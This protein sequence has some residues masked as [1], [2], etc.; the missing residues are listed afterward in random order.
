MSAKNLRPEELMKMCFELAIKAW[1]RVSPNP[2]VGAVLVKN[3]KII[4]KGFHKG[5]GLAHAEIDA[6]NN[7]TEPVA[8]ATLFCNL[9]PCCHTKKRTPPCAQRLVKEKI[10][11][12]VVSNLDPNPQ[13]AGQGMR[14][15]ET[16]GI[17]TEHGLL[18]EEG[19][20][21]NEVFF[22]HIAQGRPFVH[23]KWAQTL[24]GKIASANGSSK[25][26]TSE[27]SREKVHNERLGCD[28]IMVGAGTLREDNPSLTAREGDTVVKALTRI[29]VASKADLDPNLKFFSDKFKEQSLLVLPEALKNSPSVEKLGVQILFCPED[30]G[31]LVNLDALMSLLHKKGIYS[32]YVEGGS[33]LLS[34]FVKERRFE[35]L[36]VYIAPKLL[37]EGLAPLAELGIQDINQA[38]NLKNPMVEMLG[39]DIFVTAEGVACSQD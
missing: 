7:A 39:E 25:W 11:K 33:A 35:R 1:G 18:K 2:Y 5:P 23:L 9:E 34:R 22:K 31:G 17:Q 28:A 20:R 3:G 6:I 37:G 30:N 10:A 19:E 4:G 13:V 36:S 8:G 12:V 14:L 15:L 29:V 24:D 16:A 38:M 32:L 21:L 27:K 26:I